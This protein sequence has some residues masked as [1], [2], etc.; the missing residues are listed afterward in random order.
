MIT[1][2]L[3]LIVALFI[4]SC[5]F[6]QNEIIHEVEYRGKPI[7]KMK[8]NEKDVWVLLDTGS[9]IS[10]LNSEEK[11]AYGFT[12]YTSRDQEFT[13]PG[14]G[15]KGNQLLHVNKAYLHFGETRL[16]RPFFAFDL[17]TVANSIEAR[18]GKRIVAIIGTNMMSAYGFVIDMGNNTVAMTK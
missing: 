6:A 9:A 18:T 14:F 2:T 7:I 10:I 4:G 13:V 5:T 15:S 8:L 17:S 1:R 3:F 12:T 11:E 16:R